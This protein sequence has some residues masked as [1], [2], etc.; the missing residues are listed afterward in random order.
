MSSVILPDVLSLRVEAS[1]LF[2]V[3]LLNHV[4]F[5]SV[6]IECIDIFLI[7]TFSD[8]LC[9]GVY[10]AHELPNLP[11]LVSDGE[12]ELRELSFVVD[13]LGGWS[14]PT[15]RR[16][17]TLPG[18]IRTLSERRSCGDSLSVLRLDKGAAEFFT[19][20]GCVDSNEMMSV[21]I[22]RVPE[23]VTEWSHSWT[24]SAFNTNVLLV[25]SPID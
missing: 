14:S 24:K 22:L 9:Q 6:F 15:S 19:C 17:V 10:L 7:S 13:R 12:L 8:N 23:N 5:F 21:S 3:F 20:D 1:D 25:D 18:S 2:L 11:L 16:P 4:E